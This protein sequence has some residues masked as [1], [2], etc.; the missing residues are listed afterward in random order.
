[1]A[2]YEAPPAYQ[3]ERLPPPGNVTYEEFLNW[4]DE[5]THAEWVGGEIEMTSPASLGHQDL[6]A[7]LLGLLRRW[8]RVHDLG[9]II[10]AGFQMHLPPPVNRGREPDLIFVAKAHL[11][12]LQP[13]YLEGPADVA[14][15]V[16]SPE[17]LRRDRQIKLDEYERA[18][19][20][21]YWLLDTLIRQA[22]FYDLG[23]GGHYRIAFMGATG[24]FQS[25]VLSGLQLPVAWLW[26]NPLPDDFD[27]L[28]ALG[29]LP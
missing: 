22:T 27:A 28:R 3:P 10:Q 2:T 29:L 23:P 9:V 1:M 5:D 8:V 19:V 12:R 24:I 18:G 20:P 7:F 21:E 17:S 6:I 13:T 26:Q 11:H 16:T 25:Q 15:E 14:I 4:C